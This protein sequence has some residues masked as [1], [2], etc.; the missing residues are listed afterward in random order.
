MWRIVVAAALIACVLAGVKNGRVLRDA[1]LTGSCSSVIASPSSPGI[2]K[3]C[4]RGRLEGRPDLSRQGCIAAVPSGAL[5]YWRCPA[6]LGSA[7]GT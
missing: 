4:K 1:G 5:Q 6:Q 2:W 7:V 3:V